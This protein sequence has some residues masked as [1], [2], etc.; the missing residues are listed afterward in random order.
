MFFIV[1]C[2]GIVAKFVAMFIFCLD[3]GFNIPI[4]SSYYSDEKLNENFLKTTILLLYTLG[5][6]SQQI[7][8]N[9]QA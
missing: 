4:F 5:K 9:Y 2:T 7:L 3:M 6:I 8:H 1:D